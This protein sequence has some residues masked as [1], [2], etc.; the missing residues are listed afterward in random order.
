MTRSWR[1][2]SFTDS[3]EAGSRSQGNFS[4]LNIPPLFSVPKPHR[5][6][7]RLRPPVR[8][9]LLLLLAISSFAVEAR[10]QGRTPAPE[11]WRLYRDQ[12]NGFAFQ[13]PPNLHVI[14]SPVE[15]MH[16]DGLVRAVEV[17]TDPNSADSR[18]SPVLHMLLVKCGGNAYC[19]DAE[20]LRTVCDRFKVL[21]FGNTRAF[22]CIEY[23]SAACHWS[24]RV[25]LSGMTLRV[26][27]PATDHAAHE[28]A[29]RTL[30]ECADRLVPAMSTYPI[31]GMFASFRFG[32]SVLGHGPE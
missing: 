20:Q 7:D 32:P 26:M 23:G 28:T 21:P 10:G 13:Y 5:M 29:F 18:G 17:V 22:Q 1:F 2:A 6:T 27:T 4:N 3:Q 14:E 15:P 31:E 9:L 24:A 19:P 16:I 30:G 11:T 8:T 12:V 25:L